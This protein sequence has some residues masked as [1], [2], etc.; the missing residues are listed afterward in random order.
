MKRNGHLASLC[1]PDM[2]FARHL[3]ASTE[4][5]HGECKPPSSP[6]RTDTHPTVG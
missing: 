3:P 4:E 6:G 5:G 2:D 1:A